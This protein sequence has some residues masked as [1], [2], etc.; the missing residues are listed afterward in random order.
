VTPRHPVPARRRLR[1]AG[2]LIATLALVSACA[3]GPPPPNA[4]GAPPNLPPPTPS[5]SPTA[6][7]ASTVDTVATK[8]TTPWG[9][10]FLPD[11]TALVTERTTGRIVHLVPP[12]GP[13]G[14][15]QVPVGVVTGISV[16]PDRGLL[17]LAVSPEYPKDHLVYVYYTTATDNRIGTITLPEALPSSAP[18]ASNV[19]GSPSVPAGP[20]TPKPILTGIPKGDTGN[21]G[22]LAFG[23][24][25]MLY[26]STGDAGKPAS[27]VD[28]RSLAGKI[29]R[30]TPAGAAPADNPTKG[31][32][33]Y[34]SGLHDVQG[35][36]WSTSM[37]FYAVD[38]DNT[39]DRLL[40][41][42]PG[43]RYGWPTDTGERSVATWPLAES[44]CSGVAV[45]GP[46][47]ATACPT[48]KQMWVV[49]VLSGGVPVGAPEGLLVHTFG[50]LHSAVSAPDG[51]MWV[52]T[53]N[54]DGLG[55]PAQQD[56]RIL[57]IVFGDAGGGLS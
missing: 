33:V 10:G 25:N 4:S 47:V 22:A 57:R 11:G 29:L 9:I 44:G 19:P 20:L 40:K 36:D 41:I 35:F 34:A 37:D 31:S 24:D 5:A 53:S 52:T 26:A 50:R 16:G 43:H 51:S 13:D 18:Q 39:V 38:A 30:L 46:I 3:F 48:S 54:T 8:L 23:P 7:E 21:G 56:D 17:G 6:T 42:E 45:I 2:A 55:K 27:A 49:H 14:L 32:R 28:P 15:V 12:N 1:A